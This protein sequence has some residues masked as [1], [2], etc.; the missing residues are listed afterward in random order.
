MEHLD[1]PFPDFNDAKMA[2]FCSF[3][4]SSS[5]FFGGGG[6]RVGRGIRVVSISVVLNARMLGFV[7]VIKNWNHDRCTLIA[8][9]FSVPF[10]LSVMGSSYHDKHIPTECNERRGLYNS[11]YFEK[12]KLLFH[13]YRSEQGN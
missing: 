4:P 11:L 10:F 1:H 13:H 6:G 8:N 3:A 5:F 2:R 7:D 12:V 9:C